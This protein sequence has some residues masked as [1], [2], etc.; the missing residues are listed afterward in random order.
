M[1]LSKPDRVTFTPGSSGQPYSRSCPPPP[2]APAIGTPP[3]NSGGTGGGTC[4]LVPIL[5]LSPMCNAYGCYP[6]GVIVLG[7]L[8]ECT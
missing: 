7:W 2:P 5:N 8:W 3:T 6:P 1:S 4:T